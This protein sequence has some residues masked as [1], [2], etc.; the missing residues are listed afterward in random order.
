MKKTH[1]YRNIH[2][3]DIYIGEVA[4]INEHTKYF[5]G[6]EQPKY[7]YTGY[8]PI[9]FIIFT[10]VDKTIKDT[11]SKEINAVRVLKDSYAFDLLTGRGDYPVYGKID[12]DL[13]PDESIIVDKYHNIGELFKMVCDFK[14]DNREVTYDDALSFIRKL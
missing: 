4:Y 13:V 2:P 12:P 7:Y 3:N 10:L 11:K 6:N 9:R 1:S 14:D 8:K 5:D